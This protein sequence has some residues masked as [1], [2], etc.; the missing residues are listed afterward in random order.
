[1]QAGVLG[2]DV[3]QPPSHA[4]CLATIGHNLVG[5]QLHHLAAS[6][7]LSLGQVLLDPLD[8]R[9]LC[10]P[11]EWF[12][13]APPQP[14]VLGAEPVDLGSWRWLWLGEEAVDLVDKT[15]PR[16]PLEC[17][18]WHFHNQLPQLPQLRAV[19]RGSHDGDAFVERLFRLVP[20]AERH[21]VQDHGGESLPP[22]RDLRLALGDGVFVL[23]HGVSFSN[24]SRYSLASQRNVSAAFLPLAIHRGIS[25]SAAYEDDPSCQQGRP[26]SAQQEPHP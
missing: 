1:M 18:Q 4:P 7:W 11:V 22:R 12:G 17:T 3:L 15:H 6:P 25:T 21:M 14:L 19:R 9:L 13:I 24:R 20:P 16:C 26:D 23:V 5:V 2:H 8:Y 10:V